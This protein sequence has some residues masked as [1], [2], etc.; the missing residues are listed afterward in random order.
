L[1]IVHFVITLS[2]FQYP[3]YAAGASVETARSTQKLEMGFLMQLYRE[4]KGN[5]DRWVERFCE[6]AHAQKGDDYARFVRLVRLETTPL[7]NEDRKVRPESSNYFLFFTSSHNR[8]RAFDCLEHSGDN[9]AAEIQYELYWINAKSPSNSAGTRPDYWLK[10]AAS[11]G[12]A[13]AQVDLAM[14]I[15]LHR[16]G[17]TRDTP[18]ELRDEITPE[19]FVYWLR[20]AAESGLPRGLFE[21]A[22]LHHGRYSDEVWPAIIPVDGQ[23]AI[24]MLQRI[25][26]ETRDAAMAARIANQSK[27]RIPPEFIPSDA[28]IRSMAVAHLGDFYFLGRYVQQ[29]YGVALK[30]YLE[31]D[32]VY[33]WH[34]RAP[35]APVRTQLIR[36]YER[37]LGT[38]RDPEKARYYRQHTGRDC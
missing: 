12:V 21:Y 20:Q 25:A 18:A 13:N 8:L 38:E 19:R 24:E 4:V 28:F 2:L 23:R 14:E 29:D 37:G 35:A 30:W 9:A 10:K 15:Y 16:R 11:G 17:V 33:I 6:I 7:T 32:E 26:I 1:F 3:T 5:S 36:M 34:C 27:F 31:V 22:K